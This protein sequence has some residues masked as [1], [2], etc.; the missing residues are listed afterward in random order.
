MSGYDL[1][2][3]AELGGT[4]WR[5]RSDYRAALD[6]MQV[7]ADPELTDG[8]RAATALA[9]FYPDWEDMPTRLLQE[10]VDWLYWFIAGG[11]APATGRRPR[12]MDWEQDFPLIAAPV[13]RVLGCEVRSV[14][15]LHWWSFLAAYREIGDC[16]FAQVVAIR[17]K[18]AAGRKLDKHE[19]RFYSENR[20]LVDLRRNETEAEAQLF[21][22]WTR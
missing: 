10:A 18:R 22:E 5:I 17:K 4:E 15:Y 3:V 16:T 11:A 20:E 13:N 19:Q 2:T 7:M 14:E 9:V 21:R 6:V 1:P 12:L 8:E